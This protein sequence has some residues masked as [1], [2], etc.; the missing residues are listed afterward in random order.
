MVTIRRHF[1]VSKFAKYRLIMTRCIL[2]TKS[3]F[4]FLHWAW[5]Y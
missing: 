2:G 3:D 5:F 1:K 4:Y